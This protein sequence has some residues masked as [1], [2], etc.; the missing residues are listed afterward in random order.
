MSE[1][2]TRQV[3]T[4]LVLA[5]G[6]EATLEG[7]LD[8]LARQQGCGDFVVTVVDSAP[9]AGAA[10]R[11]LRHPAVHW[12][13]LTSQ[14]GYPALCQRGMG[15]AR[16]DRVALLDAAYR[17]DPDWLVNGLARLER[18]VE[19]AVGAAEGG[20]AD[21]FVAKSVLDRTGIEVAPGGA[22]NGL[23]EFVRRCEAAA[24]TVTC[25]TPT[26]VR[27]ASGPPALPIETGPARLP[28]PGLA[29]VSARSSKGS[30]R[31]A[32]RGLISVVVCSGGHRPEQLR[33]CLV[34]LTGLKDP[35]FELFLVDNATTPAAALDQLPA[36]VKHVHEPRRG[37]DRARNRGLEESRGEVVAFVDDDC[38]VD[39]NWL[40]GI[41]EAFADPLVTFVTGRVRPA[42]LHAESQQ[43][44]ETR[45]SFDRGP[46][47]RRFTRF[48]HGGRS[49]LLMGELGTGANM[50]FRRS[51]LNRLGGFD[52]NLDMGTLIGGGGDLDVFARALE[53]GEV[54]HYAADAVVF[55]HHRD[56][57]RKLRWQTWG[58]GLSQGAMCAKYL[59]ELRG[60][61]LHAALRYLRLL[62]EHRARLAAGRRGED[63]FPADLAWLELLGIVVG[64]VAYIASGLQQRRVG[65]P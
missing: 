31:P 41:R 42:R 44:F 23:E 37:L 51:L 19:V 63:R 25:G 16:S 8:G 30:P 43:W 29:P 2:S 7:C 60:R 28:H 5:A 49:P 34:S 1:G 65:G 48:D 36:G 54:G 50:A 61:R 13:V 52:V 21:M 10:D 26:R 9:S 53:A 40:T 58:Y 45:F 47:P 57:L 12:V 38:E 64:P 59:F 20:I 6:R 46:C 14:S 27:R 24:V 55:H 56:T 33:R 35:N 18:G 11:A 32:D 15:A 3:A 17:P 4:V 22:L 39:P 62:R